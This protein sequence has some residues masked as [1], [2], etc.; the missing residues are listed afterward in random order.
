MKKPTK[1]FI[2]RLLVLCLIVGL[3]PTIAL[4]ATNDANNKTYTITTDVDIS[5]GSITVSSAAGSG[6]LKHANDSY[7]ISGDVTVTF[8][9]ASGYVFTSATYTMGDSTKTIVNNTTIKPTDDVVFTSVTFTQDNS[10]STTPGTTTPGTTDPGTTEPEPTEPSEEL[11]PVEKEAEVKDGVAEVEVTAEDLADTVAEAKAAAEEGKAPVAKIKVKVDPTAKKLEVALPADTMKALA[12]VK[13][14]KLSIDSDKGGIELDSTALDALVDQAGGEPITLEVESVDEDLKPAQKQALS[15]AENTKAFD[16]SLMSGDK[17]ISSFKQGKDKGELT[18]SLPYTLPEGKS[19][20][21]LR[22]YYVDDNGKIARHRATLTDGKV[23]FTTSHLSTY[24]ITTSK[25]TREFTDNPDGTWYTAWVDWA[26]ENG[27][28]QGYN[29]TD[30]FAPMV[31]MD[32]SQFAYLLW[33]Y[34]GN[35]KAPAGTVNP[36]TDVKA[37]IWYYDAV[38]WAYSKGYIGGTSATTFSPYQAC[39]RT[40]I[41]ILLW[42]IKGKPAV[43]SSNTFTDLNTSAW[44]KDYIGAIDWAQDSGLV[45]GDSGKFMPVDPCTRAMVVGFLNNFDDLA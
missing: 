31:T 3:V 7:E 35:P 17:A 37:G 4:A 32:R 11:V 2:A 28:V 41:T 43:T 30:A 15:T 14:A 20:S 33:N 19:N 9:P 38:M 42:N 44:Y 10:G 29:G 39:D 8:T 13:G 24:V 12:E 26:S 45:Q 21:D 18:I 27:Y 22:V 1:S 16:L 34:F 5:N 36:F 25:L 40:Q 23:K 6:T